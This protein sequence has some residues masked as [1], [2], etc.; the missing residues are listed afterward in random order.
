MND[1][2]PDIE[3]LLVRRATEGLSEAEKATLEALLAE[4][5]YADSDDYELAA[6]AAANAF[7]MRTTR[8]AADAPAHLKAKL[9][10]DADRYFSTDTVVALPPRR[11]WFEPGWAV[12][13]AL[14]LA[15]LVTFAVDSGTSLPAPGDARVALLAE[16]GTETMPWAPPSDPAYAGVT[17]D[18]VWNDARQEGY[19]RLVGMPVNDPGRSQY[20]LWVVDPDRDERPVDGGVFDI[21]AGVGEVIV[22]IDVK[23]AVDAPDAFAITR[24]QPGGVVVSAGPLLVVA[25]AG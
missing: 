19:L 17:G 8:E 25:S 2:H 24:E 14:A 7:A 10:A 4:H 3:E 13:A 23:L 1:R 6:A 20:Q 11:R 16:A 15:L 22:P 18:V 5:G 21:P 9:N 12:A